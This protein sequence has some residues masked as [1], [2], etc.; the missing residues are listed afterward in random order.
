[1]VAHFLYLGSI[2]GMEVNVLKWEEANVAKEREIRRYT[3]TT[4]TDTTQ[5]G[6]NPDRHNPDRLN[7]DRDI[8][9]TRTQ[10]RQDTTKTKTQPR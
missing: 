7:L 4:Q 9:Q 6:H 1:M 8:T 3:D 2:D 10:L 5:T